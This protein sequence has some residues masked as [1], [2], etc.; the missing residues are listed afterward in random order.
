MIDELDAK[1]L[2]IIHKNARIPNAEI[3]RR[4]EMAPSAVLERIRKLEERGIIEGYEARLNAEALGLGLVAFVFVKTDDRVGGTNTA[5]QIAKI[6][7][8]QEVH[9]VVGEDCY[10]LKVRVKDTRHLMQLMREKLGK[11]KSVRSTRTTIVLETIKE[12]SAL[13]IP[14]NP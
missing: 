3:A 8:V 10:L 14:E 5:R 4:V 13:L 11:M 9:D 7:E 6:P 12:S 1:I 2:N